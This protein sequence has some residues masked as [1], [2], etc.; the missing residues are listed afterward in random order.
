MHEPSF[1]RLIDANRTAQARGLLHPYMSYASRI[2]SLFA[3][4]Q[5]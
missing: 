2:A 4:A 5:R 3:G 1:F